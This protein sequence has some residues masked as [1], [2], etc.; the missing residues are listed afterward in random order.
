M[1]CCIFCLNA[2]SCCSRF[3][4]H[5]LYFDSCCIVFFLP[6]SKSTVFLW[7]WILW[8]SMVWR[9]KLHGFCAMF[10]KLEYSSSDLCWK[11]SMICLINLSFR[12]DLLYRLFRTYHCYPLLSFNRSLVSGLRRYNGCKELICLA[13]Q[14]IA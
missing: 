5:L 6:A 4:E 13:Y 8:S 12:G 3:E 2:W 10:W 7:V 1:M 9:E 11:L 14:P